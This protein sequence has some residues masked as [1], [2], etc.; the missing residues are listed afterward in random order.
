MDFE[1]AGLLDGLEGEEREARLDLLERLAAD[2]VGLDE[3]AAAVAEDRLALLPVERVFGAR[4]TAKE[5]EERTGLPAPLVIQVRRALGL[6]EPG[7]EDRVFS[8]EDLAAAAA[9]KLAL[10]AGIPE[11]A[12]IVLSRVLGEGMAK[13]AVTVAGIFGDAFLR[14]GDSERDVALRYAT[15]AKQ[16]TPA[17]TPMLEAA[18]NGH[19]RE[20]ARRAVIGRAERERGHLSVEEETV[21]CFVD[22]VGFTSLGAQVGAEEL[23]TVATTLAELAADV[24][25]HPVRLVKTIGDA[26]MFVSHDAAPMVA[27]ALSL[28]D[29]VEAAELPSLRAGLALGPA[30]NRGGDWYGNTV[31]LASRVTGAA[32]PGSVLGTQAVRDAAAEDFAWSSAGRFKLKGVAESVPLY[33]ARPAPQPSVEPDPE[34]ST[35]ERAQRRPQ[36]RRRREGRS[37][38]RGS[39]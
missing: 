24:A 38:R 13:F 12:V 5:I 28:V 29:A 8:D 10:D 15:M 31:N 27:A 7:A 4:Y 25:R 23:G 33:R 18:L 11:D 26:A 1:A 17:T 2:G 6:V 37:R 20:S 21:V 39:S 19:V 30:F 16:L 32:R 34:Q 22:L 35:P 9:I 3:L 14:P 36:A